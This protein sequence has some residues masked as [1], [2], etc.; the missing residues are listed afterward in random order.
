MHAPP[1][2]FSYGCLGGLLSTIQ[3]IVLY[4][5]LTNMLQIYDFL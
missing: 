4:P 5:H 3:M 2:R 1:E